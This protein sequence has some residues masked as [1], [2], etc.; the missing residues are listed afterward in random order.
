MSFRRMFKDCVGSWSRCV[1]PV[2]IM[3]SVDPLSRAI[4]AGRH[5]SLEGWKTLA[6]M[7]GSYL[8]RE[9]TWLVEGVVV[10]LCA[11]MGGVIFET[12]LFHIS[13]PFS[14]I[15]NYCGK[16]LGDWNM[17]F[18]P[19]LFPNIHQ[20]S[21]LDLLTLSGMVFTFA[22]EECMLLPSHVVFSIVFG[23]ILC[24]QRSSLLLIL[25][26]T[27][28]LSPFVSLSESICSF[29]NSR[30]SVIVAWCLHPLLYLY[31]CQASHHTV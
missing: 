9:L 7:M 18:H 5:S 16:V 31:M 11:V 20:L 2:V 1:S 21:S 14:S 17:L 12:H 10:N 13:L 8:Y 30:Y 25:L 15:L 3:L 28:F 23:L 27:S 29:I 26:S 24:C 6:S 4:S 22:K 19:L